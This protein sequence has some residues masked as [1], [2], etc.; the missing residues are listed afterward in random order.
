MQQSLTIPPHIKCVAVA[1]LPC[2]MIVRKLASPVRCGS[3][4]GRWTLRNPAVWLAAAA[5]LNNSLYHFFYYVPVSI[6]GRETGGLRLYKATMSTGHDKERRRRWRM[7]MTIIS[8]PTTVIGPTERSAST[9]TTVM[10]PSHATTG[11]Y[12]NDNIDWNLLSGLLLSGLQC[13]K[14][15]SFCNTVVKLSIYR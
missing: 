13:T 3:F 8:R 4:A 6:L 2:E 15:F 14:A 11:Y 1:T 10:V 12:G 9:R 7:Q 5:I